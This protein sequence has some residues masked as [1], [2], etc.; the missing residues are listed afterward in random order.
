MA[1]TAAVTPPPL[2]GLSSRGFMMALDMCWM[3]HGGP[4]SGPTGLPGHGASRG[5]EQRPLCVAGDTDSGYISSGR[6]WLLSGSCD[7][8]CRGSPLPGH[9]WWAGSGGERLVDE[10]CGDRER[11]RSSMVG[12]CWERG[13]ELR[14]GRRTVSGMTWRGCG[15]EQHWV[16]NRS[17]VQNCQT[18]C[19]V[20]V[21]Q[22]WVA[23]GQYLAVS[24]F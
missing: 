24:A 9:G 5:V 11:C 21:Q 7:R 10:W 22:K 2:L 16:N 8:A 4:A 6:W 23:L 19:L 20:P 15:G 14:G 18:C 12:G 1:D 3:T 17:F 13:S